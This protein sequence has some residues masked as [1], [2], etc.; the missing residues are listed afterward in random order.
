M[1]LTTTQT[2]SKSPLIEA[3]DTLDPER[4]AELLAAYW[5]DSVSEYA[6]LDTIAWWL[7]RAHDGGDRR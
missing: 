7:E 6:N 4:A 2:A 1:M 3:G 5:N